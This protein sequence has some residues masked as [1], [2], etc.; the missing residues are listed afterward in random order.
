MWLGPLDARVGHILHFP[1]LCAPRWSSRPM[2]L[3]RL[4]S[5]TV[6]MAQRVNVVRSASR[7]GG[8]VI[9]SINGKQYYFTRGNIQRPI[10]ENMDP[11]ELEGIDPALLGRPTYTPL[12]LKCC[13]CPTR[14]LLKELV[15][16]SHMD[17]E[18]RSGTFCTKIIRYTYSTHYNCC[19]THMSL[20][21]V[22]CKGSWS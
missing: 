5:L 6:T 21:S 19:R 11:Q 14:G 18:L 10:E 15:D 4:V 16:G 17:L 1:L 8:G 9:Y 20:W 22:G 13:H 12:F 2:T 7:R 3:P